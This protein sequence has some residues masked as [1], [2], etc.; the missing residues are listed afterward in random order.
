MDSGGKPLLLFTITAATLTYAAPP[1]FT[2]IVESG[3]MASLLSSS[4]SGMK[5]KSYH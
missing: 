2:A 1:E 4:K 5:Y 3:A